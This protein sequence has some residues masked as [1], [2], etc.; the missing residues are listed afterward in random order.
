MAEN[1]KMDNYG[2]ILD[3]TSNQELLASYLSQVKAASST[4]GGIIGKLAAQA[5]KSE[6]S[7][8]KIQE[9]I[10]ALRG[11]FGD[12]TE[13]KKLSKYL[14]K[15]VSFTEDIKKRQDQMY[16]ADPV[17]KF[18]KALRKNMN[19]GLKLYSPDA[20]VIS[21]GARVVSSGAGIAKT[22][23]VVDRAAEQ[24]SENFNNI[25]N[26]IYNTDRVFTTLR[27][28]M[29]ANAKQLRILKMDLRDISEG[30]E[31]SGLAETDVKNIALA[32][33]NLSYMDSED[34]EKLVVAMRQLRETLRKEG[35]GPTFIEQSEKLAELSRKTTAKQD[36]TFNRF[37]DKFDRIV[38]KLEMF[39]PSKLGFGPEL[40]YEKGIIPTMKES[41]ESMA[42]WSKR[43][44]AAAFRSFGTTGSS[45]G[46]QGNPLQ[47]MFFEMGENRE[48][49]FEQT[50]A[51]TE[52]TRKQFIKNLERG[53]SNYTKL[54]RLTKQGLA[55][56]KIIGADAEQ[57]ADELA[58][59]TMHMGLTTDQTA[60]LARNTQQ[61]GRLTG[62]FGDNLLQAVKSARSLAENMRDAGT[63]TDKAAK[64]L[65]QF[66]A[67]AKKFGTEKEITPLLEAMSSSVNL[68]KAN[69]GTFALLAQAAGSVG[70]LQD[71]QTGQ[72]LNTPEGSK[73]M[74]KG[75]R[76][77]LDRFTGG[78]SVE[79]LQ[80]ASARGDK[81][82]QQMLLRANIAIESFTEGQ[83]KGVGALE[84]VIKTLEEGT[85]TS[86]DKL[87]DIDKQLEAVKN[88]QSIIS[89]QEKKALEVAREQLLKQQDLDKAVETQ[90]KL[91]DIAR[92][93]GTGGA[94]GFNQADVKATL[95]EYRDQ[96]MKTKEGVAGTK[97]AESIQKGVDQINNAIA[98]GID[99]QKYVQL[100]KDVQDSVGELP[101]IHTVLQGL[102]EFTKYENKV[103]QHNEKV[104]ELLE[105]VAKNTAYLLGPEGLFATQFSITLLG[106]LRDIALGLAAMGGLKSLFGGTGGSLLAGGAGAGIA[107]FGLYGVLAAEVAYLGYQ[108]YELGDATI[109][110]MNAKK[111][112]LA[113]DRKANEVR[114][115]IARIQGEKGEKLASEGKVGELQKQ[116][117]TYNKDIAALERGI[118]NSQ[119]NLDKNLNKSWYEFHGP[120][121]YFLNTEK[122]DLEKNIT[123]SKKI[124]ET[125]QQKRDERQLQLDKAK[126]IATATT[127][128]GGGGG[129]GMDAA[130]RNKQAQQLAS[131]EV[132]GP[133]NTATTH[134]D[135]VEDNTR[136][137]AEETRQVKEELRKLISILT[138]GGTVGPGNTRANS[139][140][141]S[142][143]NYWSWALDMTMNPNAGSRRPNGVT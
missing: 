104:R 116:I 87:K 62:V 28:N 129:G 34:R 4:A 73:D 39:S 113:I 91:Q 29:I 107:K 70:R 35:V 68:F 36:K 63:Y 49:L 64:E 58:D 53:I 100:M 124:L 33:Q 108:F 11:T 25:G 134:L 127:A 30:I 98:G 9:L 97:A 99:P 57:T 110:L 69:Q 89:T 76:N 56:G 50:G 121:D 140:A 40:T 88:G 65:V 60:K 96:L 24:L 94:S 126:Q 22:G 71:L 48:K 142:P 74:A 122:E 130:V 120:F 27:R 93:L 102:D 132:T 92:K 118:L 115:K 128:G 52:I 44:H 54:N 47:Q 133:L 14:E 38:K 81:E 66:S 20:D 83:I 138:G 37:A 45:L 136:R 137:S 84:R 125:T 82:A 41:V 119:Q 109:D 19:A 135:G 16:S 85:K 86:G 72:I 12:S 131:I 143:P 1:P 78:R 95:M 103:I 8:R 43:I 21:S 26:S 18:E 10:T 139:K 5:G 123:A 32:L 112:S 59:W 111:E 7:R 79:D 105:K 117:D 42:D 6:D 101:E 141:A 106:Y 61:V 67:A 3:A 31:Q 55:L 23:N 13:V 17:S 80:A 114:E 51:L 15:I 90:N 2:R 75:L 77:V 46:G